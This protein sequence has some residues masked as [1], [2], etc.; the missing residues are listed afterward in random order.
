VGDGTVSLKIIDL[1]RF[2]NINTANAAQIQQALTLMG[3]AANDISVI[4]DS[5]LDWIQPGELPRVAGAKSDYY[6][7][8]TVP[9]YAKDAPIDDLSEL[10]LIKGVTPEIYYGPNAPNHTPAVFQHKLGLVA[11]PGRTPD[12]LFGLKDVFTPFSSGKININTANTN[13]LQMI[14]GVDAATA[15]LIVDHRAGPDGIDGTDDDTPFP[16]INQLPGIGLN[17][18]GIAQWGDTRSRTFEVHVT[19]RCGSASP[20]EFVAI[21]F[22]VSPADIRVVSF[23]WK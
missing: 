13:V 14:P 20:R 6:Q 15:Q 16:N 2:A 19:A 18:Q 5:I 9:Y 12:Y 1:E 21:L 3:V 4:S 22:F 11:A 7:G 23:Y 17:S 10:L 8:L